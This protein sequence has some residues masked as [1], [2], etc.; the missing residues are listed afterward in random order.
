MAPL[1]IVQ[2]SHRPGIIDLGWGVP[3]PRLLPVSAVRRAAA[4]ALRRFGPD[5]LQ[6]GHSGG[7]GPLLDWLVTRINSQEGRAIHA[8]EI[9]I[10]GGNSSALDL[11]LTL[12]TKPGDTVVLESPTYHLAIQILRDHHLHLVSVPADDEGL[13]VDA[14]AD[15]LSELKRE[16]RRARALYTV[17]TFNNPT[18]VSL[19]EWRR[20]ALVELAA[21]EELLI[22]EDDVYRELAYDSAAPRSLWSMDPHGTV[23]RI[24]SFSKSLAPGLR[25]GWLTA[26]S[27][28]VSRLVEC[29]LLDSGGGFNHFTALT[30]AMLCE[31][32]D[33]DSTLAII[34]EAY[35]AKRDALVSG[36]R[37][38]LPDAAA[39]TVPAGGFFVW[40]RLSP[41]VSSQ[42][43]LHE[44]E[45]AGVSFLLG[46]DFYS[47]ERGDDGFR[48]AF[49]YYGTRELTEAAERLGHAVKSFS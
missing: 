48:L 36:L 17:P 16:G 45:K 21:E 23:V 49:S 47:D 37:E 11:L 13:A 9:M 12:C 18:G 29:G 31:A 35:K 2:I 4:A 19:S 30:V 27:N 8:N 43:L 1:P 26:R 10:T 39:L 41:E 6:Y 7:A 22:V 44:A 3:D 15:L 34:R 46:R 25:L 42:E 33:F 28:L 14:L 40:V 20:R 38:Q 24:G 32:G 5:A